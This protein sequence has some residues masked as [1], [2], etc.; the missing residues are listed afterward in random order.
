MGTCRKTTVGLPTRRQSA[1][2]AHHRQVQLRECKAAHDIF[3]DRERMQA[4]LVEVR[5]QSL[6][7]ESD[8]N[9]LLASLDVDLG[10]YAF[11]RGSEWV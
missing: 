11:F 5:I 4:A 1:R 3:P 8:P 9:L 2:S 10:R 6:L 7:I